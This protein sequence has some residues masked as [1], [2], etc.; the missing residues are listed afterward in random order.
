MAKHAAPIA[1]AS[2]SRRSIRR[3][4][5]AA[6]AAP[7]TGPVRRYDIVK[8]ATIAFVV[9]AVLTAVLAV[10]FSSPDVPP[11][12]IKAWASA[13]PIRFTKIALSELE[14]TSDSATYGPPYNHASGSVQSFRS[15]SIQRALGVAYPINTA[16]AFVLQP[17]ESSDQDPGLVKAIRE[18][19]TA[20]S[21]QRLRW[22]KDYGAALARARM[23]SQ[24]IVLPRGR[25][26]PVAR[27]L[28]SL[29]SMARA[30]G[31]DA[32]LIT[33]SA[34]Y[35]TNYTKPILFMGDSWKAQHAR[36]YWGHVVSAQHLKGSQWGVMNETGSWP[37][38]PWLWL[39]TMWYQVPPMNHSSNGDLMVVMIMTICTLALLFVP[40]IP[41]L[42]DI[43][44][45]IPLHR[46][47]WRDYYR[48]MAERQPVVPGGQPSSGG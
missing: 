18:Y 8:E 35:T 13:Q 29:L 24:R 48:I 23:V 44:R 14:G 39:Y 17:L 19:K 7:W 33:H 21:A 41:G 20:S 46:K 9:V 4:R 34:F 10:M 12:T 2:P 43:P 1:T 27:M 37:G 26:G 36:S 22:E 42:R 6:D 25:Y 11:V 3:Q 47:I 32:Q 38:Q 40:F 31:L 5:R 16:K 28:S 15:I 30:G 45:W